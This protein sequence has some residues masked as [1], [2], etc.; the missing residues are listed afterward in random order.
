MFN[1][2]FNWLDPKILNM[3]KWVNAKV[4]ESDKLDI[5]LDK[6][7]KGG[8]NTTEMYYRSNLSSSSLDDKHGPFIVNMEGAKPLSVLYGPGETE[9]FALM[10]FAG[11]LWWR[12]RDGGTTHDFRGAAFADMQ[13]FTEFVGLDANFWETVLRSE[14]KF[15]D[16]KNSTRPPLNISD[17]KKYVEKQISG[18]TA[19][20]NK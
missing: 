2:F 9:V 17:V 4:I 1:W 10:D 11:A 3:E 16:M 7:K 5:D 12:H 19:S 15:A 13:E 6:V 18:S 20:S 14:A 8:V